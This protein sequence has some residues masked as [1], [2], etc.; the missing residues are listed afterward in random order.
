MTIAVNTPPVHRTAS[1]P[2]KCP[3]MPSSMCLVFGKRAAQKKYVDAT[4]AQASPEWR[5]N[6]FVSGLSQGTVLHVLFLGWVSFFGICAVSKTE[7]ARSIMSGQ[8]D[9]AVA[10]ED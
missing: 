8:K 7:T 9:G 10:T 2:I 5:G 1:K 4:D 6:V 3:L